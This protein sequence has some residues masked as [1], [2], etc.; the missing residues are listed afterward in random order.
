[1]T[2]PVRYTLQEPFF[3]SSRLMPAV[4]VADATI[5]LQADTIDAD[6]ADP[7]LSWHYIIDA[8]G[9]YYEARD[10]TTPYLGPSTVAGQLPTAMGTVLS[11][12]ANAADGDNRGDEPL[13]PDAVYQWARRNQ[14]ELTLT[15]EFVEHGPPQRMPAT[16]L[17]RAI[18]HD[19]YQTPYG[20]WCAAQ[21]VAHADRLGTLHPRGGLAT[22]LVVRDGLWHETA[23]AWYTMLTDRPEPDSRSACVVAGRGAVTAWLST[24][25]PH[26]YAGTMADFL[27][28]THTDTDWGSALGLDELVEHAQQ[29]GLFGIPGHTIRLHNVFDVRTNQVGHI[30]TVQTPTGTTMASGPVDLR[31]ANARDAWDMLRLCAAYVDS[32]LPFEAA[33]LSAPS[34][35]R[36]FPNLNA[37]TSVQVDTSPVPP[38]P[39]ARPRDHHR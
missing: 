30:V 14:D 2:Q 10:V 13:L 4:A 28:P 26:P 37:T 1:M 9:L 29:A 17:W 20:R 7:R 33:D 22:G 11:Y 5:H 23:L 15:A 12:L 27:H 24:A 8:P 39:A 16:D 34:R 19:P 35:A 3:I 31:P 21:A 25:A 6:Q 18:T 32:A 36:A 38:V